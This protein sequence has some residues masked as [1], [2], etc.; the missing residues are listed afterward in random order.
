VG[1]VGLGD[2]GDRLDDLDDA[3][4]VGVESGVSVTLVGVY[5]GCD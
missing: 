3:R 1:G 2:L 4:N 5:P